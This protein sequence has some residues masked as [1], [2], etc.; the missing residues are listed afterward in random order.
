VLSSA[1]CDS[2]RARGN[3]ME[4]CQGRGRLILHQRVVGMEQVPQGSGHSPKLREF[5]I[6]WPMLIDNEVRFLGGVV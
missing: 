4:L 2:D 1:L 5:K 6:V 3:S